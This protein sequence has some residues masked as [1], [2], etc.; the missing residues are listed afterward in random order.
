MERGMLPDRA[1][2]VAHLAPQLEP[3]Q[4]VDL[5]AV[6][7]GAE[8]EPAR[9]LLITLPTSQ[10]SSTFR[11]SCSCVLDNVG[12]LVEVDHRLA[13][14][15]RDLVL[16][17][18]LNSRSCEPHGELESHEASL[19]ELPTS[20]AHH[21]SSSSITPSYKVLAFRE[22]CNPSC[23]GCRG[24]ALARQHALGSLHLPLLPRASPRPAL[25]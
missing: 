20:S 3:I 24:P 19:G 5:R 12:S 1:L 4:G 21:A 6:G 25:P 9:D 15:Q 13:V 10:R 7:E 22:N 18:S 11:D 23:R 16:N 8:V 17:P 2:G 14:I